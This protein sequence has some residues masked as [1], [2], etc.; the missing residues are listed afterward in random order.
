MSTFQA[1]YISQKG[2]MKQ[3][4]RT[5]QIPDHPARLIHFINCLFM[6]SLISDICE[7]GTAINYTGVTQKGVGPN[8]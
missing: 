8:T 5:A 2:K 7:S 6:W 4:Y 1:I 3:K